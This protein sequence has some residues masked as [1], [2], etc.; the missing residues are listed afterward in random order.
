MAQPVFYADLKKNQKAIFE[1]M[2][3]IGRTGLSALSQVAYLAT[4]KVAEKGF[5]EGAV[6]EN[7]SYPDLLPQA[8]VKVLRSKRK[9]RWGP[10]EKYKKRGFNRKNQYS[11]RLSRPGPQDR[12]V[13]AKG[14]IVERKVDLSYSFEQDLER[15]LKALEND[16]SFS[17]TN[18]SKKIRQNDLEITITKSQNKG[19]TLKYSVVGD[20][21]ATLYSLAK[22]RLPNRQR[23]DPVGA[24][25]KL[26]AR[27]MGKYLAYHGKKKASK[28]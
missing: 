5:A 13:F 16:K 23:L 15:V 24:Q 19:I 2:D 20:T 12:F 17:L 21:G 6:T 4:E 25:I 8:G 27:N 10:S 22:I 7:K 3:A 1:A 28:V 14:R 18:Y 26:Q 11:P 9:S